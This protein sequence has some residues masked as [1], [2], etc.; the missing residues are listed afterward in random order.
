M[1]G[2]TIEDYDTFASF[3]IARHVL[4]GMPIFAVLFGAVGIGK[5]MPPG[6]KNS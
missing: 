6:L 4:L 5:D 2:M 1:N 3:R